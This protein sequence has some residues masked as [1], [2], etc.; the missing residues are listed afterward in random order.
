M[1]DQPSTQRMS[2]QG[3]TFRRVFEAF[4]RQHPDEIMYEDGRVCWAHREG[5]QCCIDY[6]REAMTDQPTT[7]EAES[8]CPGCGNTM[9]PYDEAGTPYCLDEYH[10]RP[11]TQEAEK[12]FELE[13]RDEALAALRSLRTQHTE[14]QAEIERL[15][16]VLRKKGVAT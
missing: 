11:T 6:L 9:R 13:Y 10:D 3:G 1:T 16:A 5:Q 4:L 7:Q 2:V 14:Q 8:V 15:K 12:A